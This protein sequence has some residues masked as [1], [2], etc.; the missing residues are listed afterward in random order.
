MSVTL[1]PASASAAS[2]QADG[3]SFNVSTT[4]F[5]Q[6]EKTTMPGTQLGEEVATILSGA[7]LVEAEDERYEL[8]PGEGIVIPPRMARVWTCQSSEGVLYRAITKLAPEPAA[9]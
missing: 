2:Q 4:Y 7:F 9:A 5:R 6:G 1:N 8:S 3:E